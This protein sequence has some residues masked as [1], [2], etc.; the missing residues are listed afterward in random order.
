MLSMTDGGI[1]LCFLIVGFVVFNIRDHW[2]TWLSILLDFPKNLSRSW[3]DD[4]KSTLF[5]ILLICALGVVVLSRD[6]GGS[7]SYDDFEYVGENDR[8]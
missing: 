4:W 6:R 2:Y 1:I 7:S 5:L 8:L 3:R